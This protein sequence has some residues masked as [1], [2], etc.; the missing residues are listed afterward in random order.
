MEKIPTLLKVS[1]YRAWESVGIAVSVERKYCGVVE[2]DG[3]GNARQ[4]AGEYV[5]IQFSPTEETK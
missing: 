4:V 1:C 2:S 5:Y 3:D